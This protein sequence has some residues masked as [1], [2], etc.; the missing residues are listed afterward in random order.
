MVASTDVLVTILDT[1]CL[2]IERANNINSLF[3]NVFKLRKAGTITRSIIRGRPV[4]VCDAAGLSGNAQK[5][6]AGAH[7]AGCK[8][9]VSRTVDLCHFRHSEGFRAHV[10]KAQPNPVRPQMTP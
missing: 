2:H 5:G 4:S 10:G 9:S 8:G 6:A 1:C 3:I 7:T